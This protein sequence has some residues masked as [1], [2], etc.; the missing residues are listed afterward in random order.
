M[1]RQGKIRRKFYNEKTISCDSG[2]C[3]D[4]EH[5]EVG[6]DFKHAGNSFDLAEICEFETM[7]DFIRFGKE[8]YHEEIRQFMSSVSDR[9]CKID[10][11][12]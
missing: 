8:P 4:D 5:M 7:E 10:Y 3:Y 9:G 2:A 11:E 6:C 1:M 12:I